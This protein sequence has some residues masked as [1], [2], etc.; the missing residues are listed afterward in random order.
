[1]LL[2][3]ITLFISLVTYRKYY[4]TTLKYFPIIIAYTFFNEI[5]GYLVRNYDDISFITNLKYRNVN[6]IIYNIYA[7]IFFA[8]FYH[9]Y[10]RLTVN[11][12]LK[13]YIKIGSFVTVLAFLISLIFQNPMKTNL[14]YAIAIGSWILV[15]CIILNYIDKT[16]LQQKLLQPYNLMFWVSLSLLIFYS[17]FPIL[18]I[19]GY[20]DYN[21][22]VEYELRT[23]LRVLIMVMYSLLIIGFLKARKMAFQ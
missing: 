13:T 12:A 2:Y 3:A 19:I 1:M 21:T 9:V 7:A 8:F 15:F 17:I 10:W 14:F 5:V 18:F 11:K 22:W 16:I 4:D 20:T 6:E 23:V